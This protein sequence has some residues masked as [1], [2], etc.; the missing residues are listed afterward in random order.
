MHLQISPFH[1][2]L[3]AKLEDQIFLT[4]WVDVPSFIDRVSEAL[5]H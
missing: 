4:T 1:F 2:L 3:E 5:G